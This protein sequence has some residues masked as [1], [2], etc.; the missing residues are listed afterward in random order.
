MSQHELDLHEIEVLTHKLYTAICFDMGQHPPL[1]ILT[2]LFL[3]GSK[4]INNNNSNPRIFTVDEFIKSFTQLIE[5]GKLV[6][7]FENEVQ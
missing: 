6:S 5:S 4:L 7:F 3:P 2:R 1:E